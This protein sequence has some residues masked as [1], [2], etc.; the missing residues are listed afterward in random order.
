M[1]VHFESLFRRAHEL[2]DMVDVNLGLASATA[3]SVRFYSGT[4][5][6]NTIPSD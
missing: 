3:L 4:S 2:R 5:T 1:N 6:S